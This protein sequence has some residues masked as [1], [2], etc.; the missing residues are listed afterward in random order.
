[1]S[2]K[3]S[4]KGLL[5]HSPY[6]WK[7]SLFR[8]KGENGRQRRKCLV[9]GSAD[10]KFHAS[11]SWRTALGGTAFISCKMNGVGRPLQV[12]WSGGGGSW[13]KTS[14]NADCLTHW[15]PGS[16]AEGKLDGKLGFIYIL[17]Y[18]P[19]EASKR[20][21]YHW[22]RSP[23]W[24]LQIWYSLW[25]RWQP[26]CLPGG[27]RDDTGVTEKIKEHLILAPGWWRE[28]HRARGRCLWL[29]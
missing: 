24:M 8:E 23:H 29:V 25:N 5:L 3:A 14:A 10:V 16:S 26:L 19:R 20:K 7:K 4:R 27:H 2:F 1:M 22:G 17:S 18:S 15:L 28:G 13:K 6:S 21:S 9:N 11:L 12:R